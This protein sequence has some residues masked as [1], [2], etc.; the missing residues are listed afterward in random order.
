M[1]GTSK[2][3]AL[4]PDGHPE[5][6]FQHWAFFYP[7]EAEYLAVISGFIQEGLARGE[8]VLVAVPGSNAHALREELGR[9]SRRVT[10]ADMTETGRNPGRIIPEL[11]A[12]ADGTLRPGGR[13]RCIGEAAWPAR[14]A[15]ELTEVARHEALSNVAF[16]EV[17]LTA[18]CPYNLNTLPPDLLAAAGQTHPLLAQPDGPAPSPAYLGQEGIPPACLEALPPPPPQAQVL[19]YRHDLQPVRALAEDIAVQ[20]GLPPGRV[21]DLVLAVSELAANT[22]SHTRR[23][24]TLRAWQAARELVCEILDEGRIADPLAGRRRAA[25]GEAG[26][27]GLWVV[28][29]VCDLVEMRSGQAGTAVRLHMNLPG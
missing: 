26:G 6:G 25:D 5:R 10:F 29:Q 4:P 21:T 15:R 18:L 20:A 22:L 8:P 27:Q 2:A 3:D 14:S 16:A 9:E 12:F 24:G 7:G 1:D 23:G 19:H 13:V 28:N 11:R 17:P